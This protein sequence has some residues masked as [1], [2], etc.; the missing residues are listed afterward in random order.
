MDIDFS[1]FDP[2]QLRP[3]PAPLLNANGQ[4][5]ELDVNTR[6]KN[7]DDYKQRCQLLDRLS[8]DQNE[9]NYSNPHHNYYPYENNY[10][11]NNNQHH[12]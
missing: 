12:R 3:L 10:Q 4:V 1:K 5:A 6:K 7:F 8:W 9:N 11:P 2:S